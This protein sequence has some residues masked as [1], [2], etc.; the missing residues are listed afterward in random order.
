MSLPFSSVVLFGRFFRVPILSVS[1]VFFQRIA[2]GAGGKG[3][4]QKKSKIVK[5][6]QKVFRHFSTFFAQGKKRQKSSKSVKKFFRHSSTNFAAPF[7]RPLL[8]GSDSSVFFPFF[9]FSFHFQK[10]TGRHRSRDPFFETTKGRLAIENNEF[11]E[12]Q[13]RVSLSQIWGT[14]TQERKISPKRKFL[15][16][17]SRGHPGVIRADIPAQNFS[18]V[19]QNPEKKP[20]ISARTSMTRRRG[21]PRP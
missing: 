6:C 15:G 5:K 8:G 2:K 19:G 3:P 12:V 11:L 1:S 10:E 4:R 20:R 9:P 7:L 21:R 17:T 14:I 13:G 16:R 18:Q